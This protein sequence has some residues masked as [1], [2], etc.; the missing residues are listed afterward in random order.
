[1]FETETALIDGR[2]ETVFA[3]SWV[4]VPLRTPSVET[5]GS[6]RKSRIPQPNLRYF[7]LNAVGTHGARDCVVYEKERLSYADMHGAACKAASVFHSVYGVRKGDRVGI[8]ARNV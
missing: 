5:S 8:V 6:K 1:M 4:S 7:W 3:K 2:L